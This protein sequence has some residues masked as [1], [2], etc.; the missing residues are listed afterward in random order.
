MVN[1]VLA[2]LFHWLGMVSMASGEHVP[3]MSWDH[4]WFAPKANGQN[5]KVACHNFW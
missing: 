2:N 1:F 4:Y 3:I 5:A